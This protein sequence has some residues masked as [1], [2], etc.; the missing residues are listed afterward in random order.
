MF[1]ILS[2][3]CCFFLVVL[4]DVFQLDLFTVSRSWLPVGC[5]LLYWKLHSCQ[6]I[7]LQLV[8]PSNF[9][10]SNCSSLHLCVALYGCQ[11]VIRGKGYPCWTPDF[12]TSLFLLTPVLLSVNTVVHFHQFCITFNKQ[13]G[14]SLFLI[15]FHNLHQYILCDTFLL[16][17]NNVYWWALFLS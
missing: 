14:T 2:L 12:I 4:V 10:L 8:L 15:I 13:S 7:K 16:S 3:E 6:K 5:H 17:T 9:C 11:T 1:G